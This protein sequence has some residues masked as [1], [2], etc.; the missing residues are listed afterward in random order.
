LDPVVGVAINRCIALERELGVA[1]LATPRAPRA[2]VRVGHWIA[3]LD[4][5]RRR[6]Y[7]GLVPWRSV[8]AVGPA[9]R[10]PLHAAAELRRGA[11]PHMSIAAAADLIHVRPGIGL[12][13]SRSV[14]VMIYVQ[15]PQPRVV[16]WSHKAALAAEI[17]WR[18][19]LGPDLPAPPVLQHGRH[20]GGVY[21]IEAL[22]PGRPLRRGRGA[23]H[24]FE[25][26]IDRV[27]H[28]QR[29]AGARPIVP[30]QVWP[31]DE[32]VDSFNA[33]VARAQVDR[34]VCRRLDAWCRSLLYSDRA[35]F[36][37]LRHGDLHSGN[38]LVADDQITIIDWL[39][40][41]EDIAI[42]DPFR[43]ALSLRLP[44]Q[45]VVEYLERR[46]QDADPGCESIMPVID[47]CALATM[48]RI[49]EDDER[50]RGAQR[51]GSLAPA[52]TAHLAHRL[53]QRMKVLLEVERLAA[54]GRPRT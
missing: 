8:S 42:D 20:E 34:S 44:L 24:G 51:P 38:V 2:Y 52:L 29:A 49:A 32:V 35:L 43:L 25:R 53:A 28:W 26:V 33:Q 7:A 1:P 15:S 48:R 18:T 13:G 6:V 11:R 23:W 17:E 9:P 19:R 21:L 3:G 41:R 54:R 47:Q 16:R 50:H 27:M 31:V 45:R 12:G 39:G 30:R 40:M 36:L 14:Q 5:W 46:R 22:A 4:Y 37:S 10:S